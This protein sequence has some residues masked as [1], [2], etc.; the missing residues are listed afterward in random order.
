[1]KIRVFA[2]FACIGGK[3]SKKKS[4]ICTAMQKQAC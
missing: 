3:V 2:H 4:L 1:M